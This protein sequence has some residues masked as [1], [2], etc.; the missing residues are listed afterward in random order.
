MV[1]PLSYISTDSGVT[2]W[3]QYD[4]LNVD[5]KSTPID[6]STYDPGSNQFLSF[7]S[8]YANS[9]LGIYGNFSVIDDSIAP[10]GAFTTDYH[11][12]IYGV[13]LYAPYDAVI[14]SV[15]AKV[16]L[17]S[18]GTLPPYQCAIYQPSSIGFI[19]LKL[20]AKS[21]VTQFGATS[22]WMYFP[23]N[24]HI[25]AKTLYHVLITNPQ[26]GGAASMGIWAK[27]TAPF[28]NSL[29]YDCK[30]LGGGSFEFPQLWDGSLLFTNGNYTPS[31]YEV[32]LSVV[33]SPP[34]S[35]AWLDMKIAQIKGSK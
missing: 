10:F 23:F 27:S 21:K 11:N 12:Y 2:W 30:Y 34:P 33:L 25:T 9:K 35:T 15:I 8:L 3:D 31:A 20:L 32:L 18:T 28:Y 13:G 7:N 6:P 1:F 4:T 29:Y 5:L 17:N 26:Q 19:P 24:L 14:T 16:N 22:Y